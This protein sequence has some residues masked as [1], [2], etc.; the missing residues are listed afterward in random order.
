MSQLSCSRGSSALSFNNGVQQMGRSSFQAGRL[1]WPRYLWR[2]STVHTSK[3]N[4]PTTAVS[5]LPCWNR[6][7]K[8]SVPCCLSSCLPL[9]I[10]GLY[11]TYRCSCAHESAIPNLT[12]LPP[13]IPT[14]LVP[15]VCWLLCHSIP[16]CDGGSG[17][18]G[19][20]DALAM[21]THAT[22]RW[23]LAPLAL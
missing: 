8:A 3:Y 20:V 12:L 21:G 1:P 5:C 2:G 13:F 10:P 11:Y 17:C 4:P 19:A 23:P 15:C 6:V 22:S 16:R 7:G 14:S 18:T 9:V